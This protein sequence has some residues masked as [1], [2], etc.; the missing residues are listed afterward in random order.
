MKNILSKNNL[1]WL[2]FSAF[3]YGAVVILIKIGVINPYYEI[4]LSMI[5]IN[6]I[7]AISLNLIIG[8]TGQFS[9]VHAG[10][11]CVGGYSTAIV[12]L[13]FPNYWGLLLGILV[14]IVISAVL[15]LIIA[16][17][18]LRLRGDYLAIA[19]LG[20]SEII[21][22]IILNLKITNGAAGIIGIT[23]LVNWH[24]LFI[25]VWLSLVV[26]VNFT[27][28]SLGRSCISV[29]EDE[30][31][32]EAMGINTTKAKIIAFIIGAAIA[33]VAGAFYASCF[34]VV[35]PEIFGFSRSI[36]ILVIVVFGG[37]GSF[38]G[39]VLSSI[40]LGIIN[41]SLQSLAEFRMILYAVLLVVIMIFRPQ[42]LLGTREL[43]VSS[44]FDKTKKEDKS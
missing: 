34:Y 32:A 16:V 28:S 43:K 31:A 13:Y 21:R 35:K 17:P 24:V 23:K 37:M 44:L 29:R 39:S 38:T 26:V 15:G 7:L 5:M 11:M 14:G 42:G 33:S 25:G 18:T 20:F 8:I 40:A 10:F 22:I 27:R 30:I 2:A 1:I 36:D 6:I 19:T 9:L 12:L 4:T 3:C 41:I